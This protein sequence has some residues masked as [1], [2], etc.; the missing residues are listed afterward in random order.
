MTIANLPTFSVP[1]KKLWEQIP[2]DKQTLLLSN[3]W[4]GHCRAVTTINNYRGKVAAGSLILEGDCKKCGEP[5]A[6]FIEG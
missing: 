5:V 6:R 4:C 1:A 2:K 3:V